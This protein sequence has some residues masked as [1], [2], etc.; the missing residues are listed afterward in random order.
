MTLAQKQE[1]LDVLAEYS[2]DIE[3]LERIRKFVDCHIDMLIDNIDEHSNKYESEI[4]SLVSRE[5]KTIVVKVKDVNNLT[6]AKNPFINAQMD[7]L[8]IT[9]G[10]HKVLT[11][12]HKDGSTFSFGWGG[13]SHT[14]VS[15]EL[16]QL[17]QSIEDFIEKQC[18]IPLEWDDGEISDSSVYYNSNFNCWMFRLIGKR[19]GQRSNVDAIIK[20]PFSI[21]TETEAY[22]YAEKILDGCFNNVTEDN[23]MVL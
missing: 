20:F 17:K 7:Y 18:L 3:A 4:Y 1:I 9:R 6:I 15:D 22:S 10:E 8:S 14:I 16:I 11:V 12:I 23:G 2:D 5:P 21:K 13:G 19:E